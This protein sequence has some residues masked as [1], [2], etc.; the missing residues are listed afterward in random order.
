MIYGIEVYTCKTSIK[1]IIV[2]V[3]IENAIIK[4]V[5][6]LLGIHCVMHTCMSFCIKYHTLVQNVCTNLANFGPYDNIFEFVISAH[7]C[8][9]KLKQPYLIY[10]YTIAHL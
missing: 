3:L 2:H 1:H 10:T 7:I 6:L 8:S 4:F 9:Q 5:L